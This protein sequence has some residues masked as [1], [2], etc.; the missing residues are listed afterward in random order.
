MAYGGTTGFC[1][2]VVWKSSPTLFGIASANGGLAEEAQ[3]DRLELCF[4]G[5]LAHLRL[6]HTLL[7]AYRHTIN[8]LSSENV[9][10]LASS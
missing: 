2:F 6:E 8:P 7:G 5:L 4:S 3:H 9:S 10:A 1:R